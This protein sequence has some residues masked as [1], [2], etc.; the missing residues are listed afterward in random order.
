MIIYY[1]SRT[2]VKMLQ[3]LHTHNDCRHNFCSKATQFEKCFDIFL[4]VFENFKNSYSQ[5]FCSQVL[6]WNNYKNRLFLSFGLGNKFVNYAEEV[7]F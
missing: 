6:R 7:H 1:C 4:K 5:L 3:S 2:Q